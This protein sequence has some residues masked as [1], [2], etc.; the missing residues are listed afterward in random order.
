[1]PTGPARQAGTWPLTERPIRDLHAADAAAVTH[2]RVQGTCRQP[3]L[4][5]GQGNVLW[6]LQARLHAGEA[7]AAEAQRQVESL[8]RSLDEEAAKGARETAKR[9][10]LEEETQVRCLR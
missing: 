5:A 6:G 2:A 3:M 4:G 8:K 1:M 10:R 9:K 7:N